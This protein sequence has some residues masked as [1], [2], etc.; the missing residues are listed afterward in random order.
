MSK[1]LCWGNLIISSEPTD[2]P[3]YDFLLL[4]FF[5]IMKH[6]EITLVSN[7]QLNEKFNWEQQIYDQY[8][9]AIEFWLIKKLW[10][11]SMSKQNINQIST[12]E[13]SL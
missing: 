11:K 8:S 1:D 7:T 6:L 2:I 13:A 4:I 5:L 10:I 3:Q 12:A 9:P